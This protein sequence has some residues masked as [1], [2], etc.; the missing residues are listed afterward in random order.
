[1][2][3]HGAGTRIGTG[4]VRCGVRGYRRVVAACVVCDCV[5]SRAAADALPAWPSCGGDAFVRA[6]LFT[7]SHGPAPALPDAHDE[8][9][10]WI[11]DVR[12]ELAD[13]GQCLG[14]EAG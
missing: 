6:S 1:M 5:V 10:A 4:R 8:D 7:S 2:E 11:S 13:G 12:A 3:A 14:Y 9:G